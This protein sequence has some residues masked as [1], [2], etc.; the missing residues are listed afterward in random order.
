M[1]DPTLD[2]VMQIVVHAGADVTSQLYFAGSD[3]VT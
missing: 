1:P 2:R 3:K